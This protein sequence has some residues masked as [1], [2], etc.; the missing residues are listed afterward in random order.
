VWTSPTGR[1]GSLFMVRTVNPSALPQ[2]Q[3]KECS[4]D[5]LRKSMNRLL[6]WEKS[7]C[8]R[9][10]RELMKAAQRWHAPSSGY[11]GAQSLS[12]EVH[13]LVSESAECPPVKSST[14]CFAI[15]SP[16][17]AVLLERMLPMVAW[18]F[19]MTGIVRP[20]SRNIHRLLSH[21]QLHLHEPSEQ[22]EIL[23]YGLFYPAH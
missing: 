19:T 21:H 16:S 15:R 18:V 23:R 11:S 17:F 7:R 6:G 8:R 9:V 13:L 3:Y 5:H 10:L 22:S 4:I 20:N 1:F 2:A 12:T 14:Q